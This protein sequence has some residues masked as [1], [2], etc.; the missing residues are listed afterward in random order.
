MWYVLQWNFVQS[1][2]K[3]DLDIWNNMDGPKRYN[4]KPSKS[5]KANTIFHLYAEFKKKKDKGKGNTQ[6][7]T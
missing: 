7:Q 3:K 2:K 6:K 5:D 4:A 1:L